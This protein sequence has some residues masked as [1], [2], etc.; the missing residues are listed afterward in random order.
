[1]GI[2]YMKP[3]SIQ[4]DHGEKRLTGFFFVMLSIPWLSARSGNA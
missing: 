3:L 1:M 4:P 2:V